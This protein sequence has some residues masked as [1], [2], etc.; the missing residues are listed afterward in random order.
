MTTTTDVS[1]ERKSVWDA[2]R[3]RGYFFR[4]AAML[5]IADQASVGMPPVH[6]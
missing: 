3:R 6:G 5:T 2:Y 4:E 1:H